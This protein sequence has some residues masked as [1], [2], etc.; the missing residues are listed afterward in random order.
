MEKTTMTKPRSGPEEFTRLQ[1]EALAASSAAA[2]RT[3]EAFGKLAELNMKTARTALEQSSEQIAALMQAKDTGSLSDLVTSLAKLS[4]DQFA[5][6]ARAIYS[7][8]SETGTDVAD[9]VRKQIAQSNAQLAAAVESLAKAAPGSP[10]GANEF[11]AQSLN[12]AQAAYEQMQAAARQFTQP[13]GAE[14]TRR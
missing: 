11:I 12:A 1:Q 2:A 5:A 13:A 7:I 4:S 14:K 3:L 8:S 10:T 6:Y 9:L